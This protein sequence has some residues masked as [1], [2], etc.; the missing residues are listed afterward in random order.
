MGEMTVTIAVATPETTWLELSVLPAGLL[1][2]RKDSSKLYMRMGSQV[3]MF[4]GRNPVQ[5][6]E[7]VAYAGIKEFT[8]APLGT[9]VTLSV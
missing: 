2:K 6:F 3:I 4:C 9:T 8:Y 5:L 1:L 7:L